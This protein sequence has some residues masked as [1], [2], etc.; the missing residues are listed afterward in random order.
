M[1][2]G[3][4]RPLSDMRQFSVGKQKILLVDSKWAASHSIEFEALQQGSFRI[5][6][7]S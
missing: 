5:R 6:R 3:R 7:G 4:A 2:D 1:G